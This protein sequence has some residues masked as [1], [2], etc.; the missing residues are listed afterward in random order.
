MGKNSIESPV[1]KEINLIMYEYSVENLGFGK[2]KIYLTTAVFATYEIIVDFHN[3][4][5]RPE[6]IFDDSLRLML[7]TPEKSIHILNKWNENKPKHIVDIVHEIEG[8]VMSSS[9]L[10]EIGEQLSYRY[11]VVA[12][13]P[14][15][16]RIIIDYNDRNFEFDVYYDEIPPSINLSE[17]TKKFIKES[18]IKTLQNW[19]KN[20]T[21]RTLVDEIAQKL[22]HRLRVFYE[23]E[24]LKQYISG[25]VQ[26][27]AKVIFNVT[28]DIQTGESFEFEF[29]LF[30]RYPKEAPNITF[31][32]RIKNED[33]RNKISEFID[34]QIEYW[35]KSKYLISLIEELKEVI[36]KS[37][38]KVCALCHQFL[39][40]TCGRKLTLGFEGVSGTSEC[41]HICPFCNRKFHEHCW[42]EIYT[43]TH[44][45]PICLKTIK[46]I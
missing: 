26:S 38:E 22:E 43:R 28:I 29:E 12:L 19:N 21:I 27:G 24:D 31:I 40:P 32:S 41:K 46:R 1:E 42:N 37:S 17:E 18:Q 23:M 33:L 45:C 2:L 14:K 4:P 11:N 34:Y 7:G 9:I 3:Y 20:S 39:C 10:D 25:V 16:I 44:Q 13:G 30:D 6:I 35:E 5:E 8:L 15:K 36:L